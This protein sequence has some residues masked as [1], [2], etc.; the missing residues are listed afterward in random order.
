MTN[1]FEFLETTIKYKNIKINNFKNNL[2]NK[3]KIIKIYNKKLML[4]TF[5][6][7][8]QNL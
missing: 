4:I 5:Y 6:F 2:I 8:R 1:L 3:N 7:P